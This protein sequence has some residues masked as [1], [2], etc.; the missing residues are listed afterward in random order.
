MFIV[1]HLTMVKRGFEDG[2]QKFYSKFADLFRSSQNELNED[3]NLLKS[4]RTLR[5]LSS[6]LEYEKFL[7]NKFQ[8]KLSFHAN[9]ILMQFL[10][11]ENMIL[12]L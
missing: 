8:I 3:L 10:K 1:L 12:L 2:S 7:K 6:S 4:V 11:F 9:E 5:D